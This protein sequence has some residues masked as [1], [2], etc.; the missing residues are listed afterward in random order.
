MDRWVGRGLVGK[1]K[2]GKDNA[3]IHCVSG[4]D[5]TLWS[6]GVIATVLSCASPQS[7]SPTTGAAGSNRKSSRARHKLVA[8]PAGAFGGGQ[9]Q[10][11]RDVG[12]GPSRTLVRARYRGIL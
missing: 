1:G 11:W 3:A 8:Y 9:D 5:A 4:L 12:Q 6:P 10:D 7:R 2:V